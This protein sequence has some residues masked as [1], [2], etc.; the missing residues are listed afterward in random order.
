MEASRSSA[1]RFSLKVMLPI[2]FTVLAT[3]G[4]VAGFVLWSTG[5]SDQHALARQTKLVERA[6][7]DQAERLPIDQA[8]LAIWDDMLAAVENVDIDWIDGN[9]G[10]VAFDYYGHN[11]L[12]VVDAT[13]N[14]IYAMRDGGQVPA[15]AFDAVR[16]SIEPLIAQ[17][18]SLDGQAA[19]AAFNSGTPQTAPSAGDVM[20]IEG[21]PALVSVMPILSHSGEA[22]VP[23]GSEP[24][25]I[26]ALLL[27]QELAD[28][29]AAQYL[30]EGARFVAD[31]AGAAASYPIRNK[32]G[33]IVAWFAWQPDSPGAQI[34]ADTLPAL[35]GGLLVAGAII[36]ILLR[37][38]HNA[39]HQLQAERAEAQHR[40]LH[41]PLT[42]L[43][44]RTLFR[45]RLGRAVRTMARGEPR[46][47]LHALDLDRFKQVNDTLGHEAGDE[48][49]RQAAVRITSL[50]RKTDTLVRLG[51]DEFAIIQPD[52]DKL[53]DATALAG[54]IVAALHAPFHLNGHSIEIGVS[55]GIATAP[56]LAQTDAEL[57]LRADDALYRAKNGG[58]N[59]FCVY[60]LTED[61]HAGLEVD[62]RQAFGRPKPSAA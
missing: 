25:C 49:L 45:D 6:L 8:D 56:D 40:A 61:P 57:A 62:V 22:I 14:P 21:R 58:R 35:L 60:N 2:V 9:L 54:S 50:L 23:A 3:V 5:R 12:Y 33:E 41:D 17:L 11:R 19:I 46:L 26:S 15:S 28:M 7:A 53:A 34:M 59:R 38:L 55:I 39:S 44:N 10:S 27:D 4:I 37:N 18:R 42:G 52:I 32:A 48:L 13:V 20:L 16:V 31:P 1:R 36:A 51:G 47:A 24:F 29:L 43:G 30:F